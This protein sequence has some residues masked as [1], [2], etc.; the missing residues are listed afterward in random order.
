MKSRRCWIKLL[1]WKLCFKQEKDALL[2]KLNSASALAAQEKQALLEKNKRLE[3]KLADVES[4]E[5]KK[6]N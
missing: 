2:D 1:V 3:E 6:E 5:S 4:V